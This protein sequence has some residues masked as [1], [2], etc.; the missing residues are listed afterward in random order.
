MQ[1]AAR[2]GAGGLSGEEAGEAA[3][4]LQLLMDSSAQL[5]DREALQYV[6]ATVSLLQARH[7]ASCPT[8][9]GLQNWQLGEPWIMLDLMLTHCTI[10]IFSMSPK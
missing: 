8:A 7:P 6:A 10:R 9:L 2:A 4:V 3:A 1:G 5:R